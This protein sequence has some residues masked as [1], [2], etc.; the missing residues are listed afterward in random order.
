MLIEDDCEEVIDDVVEALAVI[1]PTTDD[2]AFAVGT[3]KPLIGAV[4]CDGIGNGEEPFVGAPPY[5]TPA[6][7]SQ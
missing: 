4:P 7:D 2:V 5:Q 6:E 1:G 3:G